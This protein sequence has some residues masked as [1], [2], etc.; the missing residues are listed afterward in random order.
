MINKRLFHIT[1]SAILAV[2]ATLTFMLES[3][4]PPIII[5]GA[6]MGL[7]NIFILLTVILLGPTESICV[8][9]IKILLG[10]LF[11]GNISAI[12]YSLPAGLV[13]LGLEII[14]VYFVK[15]I[16]LLSIS[17]FGAIINVIFQNGVFCLVTKTVEYFVFIP[18]LCIISALSGLLVGYAVYLIIKKLPKKYFTNN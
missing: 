5:P 4:F 11:S 12:M 14:L 13:S 17:V 6:R 8:L 9:I 18:Y 7:S 15:R 1:L 10:S 3:L 2:F 16:S